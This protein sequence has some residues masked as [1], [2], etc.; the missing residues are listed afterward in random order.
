MVRLVVA[1]VVVRLVVALAVVLP[2][3]ALA[4]VLPVVALAVVLPVVALAVVLPV[5]LVVPR[6]EEV[7][8]WLTEPLVAGPE[9]FT[10][11][12]V[13]AEVPE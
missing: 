9:R 10:D 13:R 6:V 1:L 11:A 2:V 3:V 8:L 12:D 5:A 4:V 7:G